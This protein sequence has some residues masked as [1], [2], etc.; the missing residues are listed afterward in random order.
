LAKRNIRQVVYNLGE[1][2]GEINTNDILKYIFMSSM[3]QIKKVCQYCGKEFIAH[4]TVTKFCSHQ[5]A[6]RNYKKQKREE[7]IEKVLEEQKHS[8]TNQPT[9]NSREYL[10]CDDVAD[11]MGIS[12]TTVYPYCI[13]GKMNCIRMNRKIFICKG[14]IDLLFTGNEPYE[15]HPVEK[16][17]LTE[18]YTMQEIVCANHLIFILRSSN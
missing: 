15:V 7:K 12:R 9:I 10:S 4:K 14:D 2:K 11:L 18:F 13:T 3:I 1:I 16:R 5:C 17:E 8:N 6:Q